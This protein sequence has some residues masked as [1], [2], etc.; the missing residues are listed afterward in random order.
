MGNVRPSER[1]ARR[2]LP[3]GTREE[4][5]TTRLTLGNARTPAEWRYGRVGGVDVEVEVE[6]ERAEA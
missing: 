2:L 4:Q 3:A 5:R 6:V 1:R